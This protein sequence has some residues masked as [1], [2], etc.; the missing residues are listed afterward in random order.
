MDSCAG[1]TEE[2]MDIDARLVDSNQDSQNDSNSSSTVNL[3][4]FASDLSTGVDTN[5]DL[6]E[7]IFYR[8]SQD[9]SKT[10]L[11]FVSSVFFD[12]FLSKI[13]SDFSKNID[14]DKTTT[15][16][17]CV[18]HVQGLKCDVTL[19]SHFSTVTVTGIGH[20][21]WRTYYFHK[22]SRSLFKQYVKDV[23][24]QD[25][26][27]SSVQTPEMK[28]PTPT[29]SNTESKDDFGSIAGIQPLLM[30]TPN[31]QSTDQ[32]SFR[33]MM[34][35]LQ[36]SDPN[37]TDEISNGRKLSFMISRVC[38]LEAIVD[39]LKKSIILLVE[40]M[41]K[42]GSFSEAVSAGSGSRNGSYT[43]AS[44]THPSSQQSVI[45]LQET[46]TQRQENP[47][48]HLINETPQ[49]I[50]VIINNGMNRMKSTAETL[51]RNHTQ[52][53]EARIQPAAS[54]QVHKEEKILLLGDSIISGVNTK[55]L[56]KGVHKHSKGGATLQHMIDELAVYDLKAFSTVIIYI[57]GNDAAN[58]KSVDWIEEKYDELLSRI[59]SRNNDCRIIIC[60]LAPRGDTDVTL[61]NQRIVNLA[62]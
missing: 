11:N 53:K 37:D 24:S 16:T 2:D 41:T 4:A 36:R 27:N 10:T 38:N 31:S 60:S 14:S 55:G 3:S 47:R 61:V 52:A 23:D 8:T 56:T 40:K 45:D 49:Q 29:L 20:K 19:D 15:F 46:S 57:A 26:Q 51:T 58:G 33:Q 9:E 54:T 34:S 22:A 18:T 42:P 48:S 30:S 21:L 12:M 7:R 5:E 44:Q 13:K 17:K 28:T 50:P 62:N 59:K 32:V 1:P 25:S 35:Q 6:L 43:S 39:D